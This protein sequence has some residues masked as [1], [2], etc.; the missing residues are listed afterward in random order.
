MITANELPSNVCCKHFY[1]TVY[2]AL[3]GVIF[4]FFFGSIIY[5][6]MYKCFKDL[7]N[8]PFKDNKDWEEHKNFI[9]T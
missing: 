1:F 8:L 2:T 3:R 7:L 5:N 9:G 4:A 6:D